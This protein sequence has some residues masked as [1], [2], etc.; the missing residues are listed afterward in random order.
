MHQMPIEVRDA[1]ADYLVAIRQQL[2]LHNPDDFVDVLITTEQI[3]DLIK[4][5]Q[6]RIEKPRAAKAAPASTLFETHF[7]NLWPASKRKVNKQGCL[8]FWNSHK[9]DEKADIIANAVNQAA[10]SADW[11]KENGEFIPMPITWLR[12]SRWEAS[13][14]ARE[15]GASSWM[16]GMI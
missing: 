6:K 5:L 13:E 7:W 2:T 12:Q 9:L 8:T 3:P 15:T 16:K 14:V 4:A 1:D 11:K 10:C